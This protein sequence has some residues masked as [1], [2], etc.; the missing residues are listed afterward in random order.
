MKKQT[1]EQLAS[2][3]NANPGREL[4]RISNEELEMFIVVRAPSK[5]EYRQYRLEVAETD[6][7]TAQSRLIESILLDPPLA[8]WS[9]LL[10]QRPGAVVVAMG[11][12]SEMVGFVG[13]TTTEKL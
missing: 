2:I 6:V 11:E 3:K 8:E 9:A 13:K 5:A 12:I 10:E 7:Y 4:W 1:A